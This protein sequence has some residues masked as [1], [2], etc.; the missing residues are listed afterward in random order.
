MRIAFHIGAHC[1]DENL[2]LRSLQKNRDVLLD[3]SVFVPDSHVYRAV[4]R[5][6]ILRLRGAPANEETQ[7]FLLSEIMGDADADRLVLSF[8]HFLCGPAKVLADGVLYPMGGERAR[9][10]TNL[11]PDDPCDLFFAIRD[12]ASFLPALYARVAKEKSWAE[13]L[14]R[15]DPRALSWVDTV[16]TLR[17]ENPDCPLTVWCNED[18]PLIWPAVLREVADVDPM[19]RLDGGYDVI[20]S[21]MAPEGFRRMLTYL[22]THPPQTEVQHR[23]VM[24]AF[25]DKFAIEERLDEEIDVPGWTEE[26]MDDLSAGYEEDVHEISRMA[27][28]TVIST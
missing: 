5:D 3:Q 25:L 13:F 16:R 10:L 1:T 11:F 22:D 15:T 20:E 24:A 23:R 6:V 8:D 28:V 2:L 26:L 12:P 14:G 18:T 27:G 19:V 17:D 9:W 7:D 21:I 4:I